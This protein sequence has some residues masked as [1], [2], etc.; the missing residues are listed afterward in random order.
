[1]TSPFQM[2]PNSPAI[3]PKSTPGGGAALPPYLQM[4]RPT[5]G[6]IGNGQFGNAPSYPGQQTQ[7]VV[8]PKST[9]VPGEA[10]GWAGAGAQMTKPGTPPQAPSQTV[11]A[12]QGSTPPQAGG[13]T[14]GDVYGFFKSDLENQRNQALA[15]TR[16]DASAR[17]VFYGTPLTGSEADINTQYLRG[18]GQLQSGMYG[19]EQ[20][21]QLARLGLAESMGW[22]NMAAQPPVPGPMDFSSLGALFGP[23]TPGQ[24][25]KTP[26]IT[27]RT[28][29][30]G[31]TVPGQQGSP[32]GPT[33][34]F[35]R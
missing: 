25:A 33:G 19:N 24:G 8:T 2:Q 1:M 12:P 32:Y 6:V 31:N 34:T 5:T 21:N 14:L 26:A 22:Q 27:P 20:Q 3:T 29:P 17:G 15:S 18:L 11:Q 4:R 9:A 23:S 35:S 10:K 28:G 30:V 16:A 7:P 13:Q